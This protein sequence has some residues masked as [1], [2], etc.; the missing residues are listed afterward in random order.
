M[1]GSSEATSPKNES[2]MTIH[3][4]SITLNTLQ[5]DSAV[6]VQEFVLSK[7]DLLL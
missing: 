6:I 7:D 3:R 1:I 2:V 4:M 5:V